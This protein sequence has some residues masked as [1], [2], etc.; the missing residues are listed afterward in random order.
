MSREEFMLRGVAKWSGL[1]SYLYCH[2]VLL[3]QT[4]TALK[5]F[6][7]RIPVK[8]GG[9]YMVNCF[10]YCYYSCETKDVMR[11]T[12]GEMYI[13]KIETSVVQ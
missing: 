11:L 6:Y 13:A 5:S 8:V 2:R 7:N 4:H 12:G 1:P 10:D 3:S 9:T